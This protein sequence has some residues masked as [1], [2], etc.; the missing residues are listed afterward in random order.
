MYIDKTTPHLFDRGVANIV[1]I[2]KMLRG[3]AKNTSERIFGEIYVA[4]CFHE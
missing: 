1:D 3:S 2:V 4:S